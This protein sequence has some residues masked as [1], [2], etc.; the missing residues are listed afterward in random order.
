[1]FRYVDAAT[2]PVTVAELTDHFGLNHNAIRQHLAK[3]CKADL[4]REDLAPP[5]GP[6]RRRLQY[7]TAPTVATAW[8][9]ESPY[10][11]LSLLLLE[12]L[13]SGGSPRQV[14]FEAGRRVVSGRSARVGTDELDALETLVARQGFAPRRVEGADAV[15]LVLDNC[16]YATAA[17]AD[18]S[19]VCELHKG[20]AEG[21]AQALGDHVEVTG[22]V[23]HDPDKAGCRLETR[24]P[25]R[26][27]SS[28]MA[29]HH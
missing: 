23:I 1:M 11:Q 24:S 9:G 18:P 21:M 8:G 28:G 14:G 4:L 27:H 10:E 29:S 16:P 3:L 20:L 6:G 22:L 17:A 26:G 7:R 25:A 13:E 12:M 19:V 15:E 5:L 2:E